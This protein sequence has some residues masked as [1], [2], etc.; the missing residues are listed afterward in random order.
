MDAIIVA[1]RSMSTVLQ[2]DVSVQMA[3]RSNLITI[4]L[5]KVR[6][7]EDLVIYI[8]TEFFLSLF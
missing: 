8:I 5:V 4:L 7:F 6:N 2:W 3:G 1:W